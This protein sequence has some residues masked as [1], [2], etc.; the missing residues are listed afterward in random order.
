[1]AELLKAT[2]SYYVDNCL[3]DKVESKA[4]AGTGENKDR[5]I[6]GFYIET[7]EDTRVGVEATSTNNPVQ[8]YLTG[9][10]K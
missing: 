1:M 6:T 10:L 2:K 3:V 4:Q 9:K 7:Y 5:N 8:L